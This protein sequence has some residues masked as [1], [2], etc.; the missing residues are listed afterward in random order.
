MMFD[1]VIVLSEG[2]TI[3]QGP[4]QKV[5]QYFE[6]FGL[7][8]GRFMN[9]ADKLSIIASEPFS[10]LT[11]ESTIINLHEKTKKLL[12]YNICLNDVERKKLYDKLSTQFSS[13]GSTREVS[14]LK[15]FKLIYKR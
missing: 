5:K 7:Q 10:L 4:P 9:P 12:H 1:K 13:I 15:Q 14:F 2:Y 3:Y 8:M 11:K 6:Q